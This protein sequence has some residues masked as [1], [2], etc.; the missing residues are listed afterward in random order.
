VLNI[1]LLLF[2]HRVSTD[3]DFR[4]KPEEI[5]KAEAEALVAVLFEMRPEDQKPFICAT[6]NTDFWTNVWG[7]VQKL[8]SPISLKTRNVAGLAQFYRTILEPGCQFISSEMKNVLAA[9][10]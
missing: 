7:E 4:L 10:R 5:T 1:F 9:L 2:L 6:D 3:P 8:P